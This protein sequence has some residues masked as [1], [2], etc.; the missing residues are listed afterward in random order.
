MLPLPRMCVRFPDLSSVPPHC[1]PPPASC[2]ALGLRFRAAFPVPASP[3][4]HLPPPSHLHFQN[5]S[6][7]PLL[8]LLLPLLL[9]ILHH[10]KTHP[11]SSPSH[12]NSSSHNSHPTHPTHTNRHHG[13]GWYVRESHCIIALNPALPLLPSTI[14]VQSLRLTLHHSCCGRRWWH[15][16]G[17]T[18][19]LIS[20]TAL[21]P[22]AHIFSLSL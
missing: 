10:P 15:W 13:Q 5:L 22:Q 1:F 17:T 3:S 14:F 2:P 8:L 12:S 18:A 20:P 16:A 6:P 21:R 4:S 7:S 11:L 9:S 19:P